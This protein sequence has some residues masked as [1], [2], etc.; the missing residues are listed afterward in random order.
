[1]Y[2][3]NDSFLFLFTFPSCTNYKDIFWDNKNWTN[4]ICNLLC[5]LMQYRVYF[6]Q[7]Y[8]CFCMHVCMDVLRE[9]FVGIVEQFFSFLLV[10]I[11]LGNFW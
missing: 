4:V 9:M 8:L 10:V 7:T 1:M 6:T 3:K 5:M 2:I 11:E